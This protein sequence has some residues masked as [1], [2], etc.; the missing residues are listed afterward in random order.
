MISILKGHRKAI[1]ALGGA[2]LIVLAVLWTMVMLP[3]MSKL[4]TDLDNT[5]TMEGT[6][7]VAN[8]QGGMDEIPVTVVRNYKAIGTEG[9]AI[10]VQETVTC[11]NSA[12]GEDLSE[13]YGIVSYLVVDRSSF[14]MVPDA[15]G[16][17]MVRDGLWNPTPG[18]GDTFVAWN[19]TADQSLESVKTGTD[20]VNGV[21]VSVYESHEQVIPA[22]TQNIPGMGVLD[23]YISTDTIVKIE[24]A[25][26]MIVDM[27]STTTILLDLSSLGMGD[28]PLPSLIMELKY[29]EA[30]IEEYADL[31]SS[32]ASMAFIFG[33]IAPW[34]MIGLGGTLIATP[35]LLVLSRRLF[36][37]KPVAQPTEAPTPSSVSA[38]V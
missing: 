34:T 20:V 2:T 37:K 29:T 16:A 4:P 17:D 24:P 22:G 23:K 32:N 38:D 1:M 27:D 5:V 31:A 13:T 28:T 36:G 35:G 9:D 19:P 14:E 25:T 10:Q 33:T 26:G 21:S 11:T 7:Y 8:P 15:A 3:S 6:Y 18:V 12:T 30:T